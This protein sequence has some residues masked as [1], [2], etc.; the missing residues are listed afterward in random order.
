MKSQERTAS[1]RKEVYLEAAKKMPQAL[2]TLVDVANKD[3]TFVISDDLNDFFYVAAQ[4]QLVA[5]PATASLINDLVLLYNGVVMTSAFGRDALCAAIIETK[6]LTKKR[7]FSLSESERVSHEM[8]KLADATP[9]DS[10]VMQALMV[11]YLKYSAEAHDAKLEL[12]EYERKTVLERFRLLQ[13]LLPD[14][15]AIAK[16]QV[17]VLVGIRSDLGLSSDIDLLN[18]QSEKQLAAIEHMIEHLDDL[19]KEHGLADV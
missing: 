4:V 9:A 11:S 8:Q 10:K 12:T 14:L 18:A 13:L 19:I 15:K 16:M 17:G 1:L 3:E 6:R 2:S 7:D 5:E